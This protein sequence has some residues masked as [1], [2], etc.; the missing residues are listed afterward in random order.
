MR[1]L[2]VGLTGT[3]DLL[4]TE[5]DTALA[6]GS[7]LMPVLAT[8]RLV[9]LVELAAV[10]A[11]DGC[12]DEGDTTVGVRI[13]LAHT[14]ATPVGMRVHAVAVLER[15]DGRLLTF[16]VQAEDTRERIGA[17][18]HTRAVVARARFLARVSEKSSGAVSDA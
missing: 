4:V 14:A 11:L 10:Q 5:A 9:A 6:V 3:V 16:R 13:D 7:G 2:R 17:G 18:T 12:L 8:P 1:D 15:I